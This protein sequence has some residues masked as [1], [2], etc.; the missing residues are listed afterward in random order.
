[1]RPDLVLH[2]KAGAALAGVSLVAALL[3][4]VVGAWAS[5]LFATGMLSAGVELYQWVRHEGTPS[6]SD[7]LASWAPGVA[8]AAVVFFIERSG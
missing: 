6:W 7:A 5:V 8:L 4:A 2:I 3:A 1:M